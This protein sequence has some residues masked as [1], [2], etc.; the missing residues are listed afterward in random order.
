[1]GCVRSG[2]IRIACAVRWGSV[3]GSAAARRCQRT[4]QVAI[5]A[6]RW[7]YVCCRSRNLVAG[8]TGGGI[9][10]AR[11]GNRVWGCTDCCVD[12]AVNMLGRNG[13]TGIAGVYVSMT[14]GAG[15]C[16]GEA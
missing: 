1:M 9:C 7:D 11:I 10:V 5:L 3:T 15:S 4:G 14:A 2:D 6:A 13:E 8:K 16:V 12:A